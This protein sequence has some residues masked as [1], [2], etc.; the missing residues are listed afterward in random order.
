MVRHMVHDRFITIVQGTVTRMKLTQTPIYMFIALVELL[1]DPHLGN[2]KSVYLETGLLQHPPASVAGF[3]SRLQHCAC[4]LMPL[5]ICHNTMQRD[6]VLSVPWPGRSHK[7]MWQLSISESHL[8][9][10]PRVP[11]GWRSLVFSWGLLC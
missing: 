8:A 11:L 4:L 10:S 9:G 5:Q 7:D 6:M 2:L 1:S 3:P